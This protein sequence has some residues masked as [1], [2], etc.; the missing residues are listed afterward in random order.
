MRAILARRGGVGRCAELIR[1]GMPSSTIDYRVRPGGPWER[2]LP[3]VVQ[4]FRGRPSLV[5]ASHAALLYART[6]AVVTGLSALRLHGFRDLPADRRVHLLIPHRRQRSSTGFVL[7]ERTIRLPDHRWIRGIACAPVARAVIDA[8]RRLRDFDEVRALVAEA[9][10]RHKC[11][12]GEL[13]DELAKA[14]IRGTRL[15]RRALREV[16][17]GVRSVAE[18]KARARLAAERIPQPVWNCHLLD[19]AGRWIAQPDAVWPELGVVLEIDSFAWH[20]SPYDALRTR[21]R[22]R[23]MT[24]LGHLVIEISPTEFF[25][26]PDAIIAEILETLATAA[27]RPVPILRLV[28]P[29]AAR[30]AAEAEAVAARA[31]A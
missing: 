23:R 5:Q 26:D 9:V 30:S 29:D 22:R 14:Q 27:R 13:A 8:T 28:P 6:G 11:T 18:A 20:T 7:I 3:G 15:P 31:A 17:A 25:N 12:L 21:A 4:T 10:Q 16:M 2:V 1:L 19:A 24:K